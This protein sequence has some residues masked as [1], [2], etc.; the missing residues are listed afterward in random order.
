[1]VTVDGSVLEAL[2]PNMAPGKTYQVTVSSVKGLE[3]SEPSSDTVTTGQQRSSSSS[4]FSVSP[5]PPCWSHF[6]ESIIDCPIFLFTSSSSGQASG[7]DCSQCHWRLSPVAVATVCGHR[8][9]LRHHLQRRFRCVSAYSR[10]DLSFLAIEQTGSGIRTLMRWWVFGL[11]YRWCCVC[12]VLQCPPQ[13][14]MFLGTLWSLR[15]AP[16]FQEHSI[17]SAFMLQEQPRRVTLPSLNSPQVDWERLPADDLL[18]LFLFIISWSAYCFL[19]FIMIFLTCLVQQL[20]HTT[21]W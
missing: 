4:P 9:R 19:S 18:W 6:V 10:V 11:T 2:L 13:W 17:Q 3:E 14:S 7:S 5:S 21:Q 1:M 16:C 20:R 15:W 8:R 12:V